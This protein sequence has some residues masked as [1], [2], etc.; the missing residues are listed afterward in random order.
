MTRDSGFSLIEMLAALAIL[1]MAG[2]ALMNALTNTTRAASLAEER[3][4]A[5][6]AANN[7]MSE[8]IAER[9]LAN[10]RDKNGVYELAGRTYDWTLDYEPTD[11]FEL[12]ALTLVIT[13]PDTDREQARLVSFVRG[14]R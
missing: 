2:V 6:M 11:S 3:A 5:S 9:H 12:S 4:L 13:D 1:S 8:L 14:E 7:V 10:L